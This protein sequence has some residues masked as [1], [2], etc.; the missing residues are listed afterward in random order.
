MTNLKNIE[1]QVTLVD[2][3]TLTRKKCGNWNGYQRGVRK[4]HRVTL[5]HT[6]IIPGIHENILSVTRALQKG[7]QLTSEDVTLILKKNSTNI[8][9]DKKMVDNDDKGFL[10]TT[11]FY[12]KED[13]SYLL[14]TEGMA[15]NNKEKSITKQLAM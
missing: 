2:I 1:T 5:S 8:R 3:R 10:L 9:F 14:Q 11:R 6:Y 15:A 12:K 13:Y 4:L 7:F